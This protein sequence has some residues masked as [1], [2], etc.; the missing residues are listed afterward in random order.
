MKD[1]K[2]MPFFSFSS[3]FHAR[4]V[5]FVCIIIMMD[6]ENVT[7]TKERIFEGFVFVVCANPEVSLYTACWVESPQDHSQQSQEL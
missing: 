4:F 2:F 7:E 3:Y 1:K 5:I 6:H